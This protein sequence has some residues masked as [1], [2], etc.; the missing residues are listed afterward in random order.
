MAPSTVG[1][2]PTIRIRATD[3][4][5][6]TALAQV[7]A[8]ASLQ[9]VYADRLVD[10]RRATCTYTGTVPR[11]ALACV[12]AGTGIE[13]KQVRRRQYVLVAAASQEA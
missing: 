7:R 4:P 6:A 2:Q 11:E 13:A 9:L 10:G 1:A 3:V 5:L 8:E 12:V